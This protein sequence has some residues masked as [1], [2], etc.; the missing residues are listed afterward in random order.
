MEIECTYFVRT[1]SF[2]NVRASFS[3]SRSLSISVLC[4]R[5]DFRL[6]HTFLRPSIIPP[7]FYD[8]RSQSCMK[9]TGQRTHQMDQD[10]ICST[11]TSTRKRV[12]SLVVF[13]HVL[14]PAAFLELT[15]NYR[16]REIRQ[17]TGVV[18]KSCVSTVQVC[19]SNQLGSQSHTV[20]L[21]FYY[22]RQKCGRDA[23][24]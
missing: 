8:Q 6:S 14:C 21:N 18:V 13:N 1:Q 12:F 9:L 4:I 19:L 22:Q 15:S 7:L 5:N 10:T 17:L 16:Q 20:K 24:K 3:H 2:V 23:D 11:D